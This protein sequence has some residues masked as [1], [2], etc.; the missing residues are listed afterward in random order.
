MFLGIVIIS[1]R[2]DFYKLQY[3]INGKLLIM[4]QIKGVQ[5]IF[6]Y[7]IGIKNMYCVVIRVI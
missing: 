4:Y 6:G 2:S 1:Y 7:K 3:Q 5:V